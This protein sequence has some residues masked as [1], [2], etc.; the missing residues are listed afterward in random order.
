M[1][2]RERDRMKDNV[3][4]REF[5]TIQEALLKHEEALKDIV[6]KIGEPVCKA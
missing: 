4:N 3:Q 6:Q 2:C 5:G 1:G